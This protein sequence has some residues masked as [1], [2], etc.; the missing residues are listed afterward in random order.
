ME[1][2]TPAVGLIFWQLLIF[3]SLFLI[4]RK[5]AW[6]P[7]LSAL[8]DRENEIE[9]ALKM[10]EETR[11]EMAKLKADNENQLAEA[12]KERDKILAE[13]RETSNRMISEAQET[14]KTEGARIIADTRETL[15]QERTIMVD[16]LR[17]EV[18]DIS[19][20]IAE[21]L[22]RKELTDKKSQQ[23]LVSDLISQANL[24]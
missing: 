24:N 17:K 22:I 3:T 6:K 15:N 9:S 14:A 4:L 16:N 13:A 18:A 11:A 7:I 10:A 12:R 20:S 23:T 8:S 21:K 2:L 5:F 19:I 1:L